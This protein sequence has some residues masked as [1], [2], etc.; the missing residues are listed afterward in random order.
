M[1]FDVNKVKSGA[2]T[3][4]TMV[5]GAVVSRLGA[6]FVP[7]DNEK[8][9]HGVLTVAPLLVAGFVKNKHVQNVALG[10]SMTQAGYLIKSFVEKKTE[11]PQVKKALGCP[12]AAEPIIIY[13]N[14]MTGLNYPEADYEE[15]QFLASPESKD[16]FAAA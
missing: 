7:I 8:V 9:K 4:G 2:T 16:E 15:R 1:K 5:A 10:A 11:N 6:G 14:E 3:V 13:A 12:D